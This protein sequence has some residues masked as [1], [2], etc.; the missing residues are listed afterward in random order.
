[1]LGDSFIVMHGALHA[2]Q[3][4]SAHSALQASIYA[5]QQTARM[6]AIAHTSQSSMQVA[7]MRETLLAGQESRRR[8]LQT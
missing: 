7:Q 3:A 8:T 4:A 2:V 1:M 6:M 5:G